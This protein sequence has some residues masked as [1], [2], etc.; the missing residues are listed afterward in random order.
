[1]EAYTAV[2][3]TPLLVSQIS[4]S[5]PEGYSLSQNFPNPFNPSTKIRFAIPQREFLSLKVYD[6]LGREIETLAE[7]IS[8]AG[9]FEVTF[10]AANLPGGVYFYELRSAEYSETKKFILIK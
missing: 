2:I 7:G 9:E 6:A 4:S 8:E 3:S 10:N 5:I 1:M